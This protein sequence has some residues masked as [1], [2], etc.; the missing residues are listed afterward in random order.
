VLARAWRAAAVS[1][2]LN[3]IED[4]VVPEQ[5]KRLPRQRTARLRHS[6][7]RE[8]SHSA[9][10]SRTF[11][12][13]SGFPPDVRSVS[14]EPEI[15]V[16]ATLTLFGEARHLLPTDLIILA[17]IQMLGRLPILQ[18]VPHL[19]LVKIRVAVGVHIVNKPGIVQLIDRTA[20]QPISIEDRFYYLA[21]FSYQS[22]SHV[23]V[24]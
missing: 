18:E 3:F 8:S 10:Y 4:P 12:A 20:H 17:S 14:D 13:R 6:L 1:F 15:E 16:S 21:A 9:S 5:A 24:A 2:C 23:I 22:D 11:A 19:K 7:C